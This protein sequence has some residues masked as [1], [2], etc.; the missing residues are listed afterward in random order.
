MGS[1]RK[2]GNTMHLLT[3]F[4]DAEKEAHARQ[5]AQMLLAAASVLWE[6]NDWQDGC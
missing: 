5:F 4:M 1:P 3:P 2:N 6:E